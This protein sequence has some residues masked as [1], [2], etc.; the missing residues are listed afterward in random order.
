MAEAVISDSQYNRNPGTNCL[1]TDTGLPDTSA[2]AGFV[3][4]GTNGGISYEGRLDEEIRRTR[5]D[6][7]KER[8]AEFERELAQLDEQLAKLD[9]L[10]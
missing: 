7:E 8:E 5:R 4:G 6:L 2:T 1:D 10:R 3:S 9:R